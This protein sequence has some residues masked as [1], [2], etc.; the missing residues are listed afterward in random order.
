VVRAKIVLGTQKPSHKEQAVFQ[1]SARKADGLAAV[2]GSRTLWEYG[3][4]LIVG[5]DGDNLPTVDYLSP[6]DRSR[7]YMLAP[8]RSDNPILLI[9]SYFFDA[10]P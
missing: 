10:L 4:V 2:S 6:Y 9:S 1:R 3:E 8:A 5:F 7:V